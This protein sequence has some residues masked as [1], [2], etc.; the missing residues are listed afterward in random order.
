MGLKKRPFI[1]IRMLSAEGALISI[2]ISGFQ[3]QLLSI[4]LDELNGIL[5]P[6]YKNK[7]DHFI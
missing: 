6:D 1:K 2:L 7:T 3:K 4:N 5:V